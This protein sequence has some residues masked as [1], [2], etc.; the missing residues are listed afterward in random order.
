VRRL[1]TAIAAFVA[2]ISASLPAGAQSIAPGEIVAT[3][4]DAATHAPI[5][6]ATVFLIGTVA[7]ETAITDAHGQWT[8]DDVE[9]GSYGIQIQAGGYDQS[10]VI[11]VEV[12]ENKH[13]AVDIA[14]VP[15]LRTIAS[16]TV[17]ASS[18][19]STTEIG[20]DS[21]ERKV[22]TSL[23]DALSKLVGITVSD[24]AYGPNSGFGISLGNH[25]ESQTGYSINGFG[26]GGLSGAVGNTPDLFTAA[27]VSFAP[28]PG[29]LGGTLNFR[30]VLPTK[31][32]QYGLTNTIGNYGAVTTSAT[33]SGSKGR[34]SVAAQHVVTRGDDQ[35]SG[36][37]YM[38]QSGQS[39]LHEA[40]NSAVG[41]VV[42]ASYVVN[43]RVSLTSSA[44]LESARYSS[45][46]STFTTLVPCGYGPGSQ[47][48]S[49]YG[50]G[51]V[52]ANALVGKVTLS[53]AVGGFRSGFHYDDPGRSL[54]GTVDPYSNVGD[55]SGLNGGFSASITSK[56]H[57]VALNAFGGSSSGVTTLTYDGV[58]LT[59]VEPRQGS[60]R[61]SIY[62]QQKSSERLR[63][64]G[65]FSVT[66]ATGSGT[67]FS[68]YGSANWMARPN[69]T[70]EGSV[71]YGGSQPQYGYAVP[72][73]DPLAASYDCGNHSI[74]LS[75]PQDPTGPQ[76]Q[77]YYGL[78]W[79]HKF[80]GGSV[81]VS[82]SR[83]NELGQGITV[84]VPIAA[85]PD[86][87]FPGGLPAYLSSLQNVWSMP[88]VCGSTPFANNRIYVSQ[89][90]GG[91]GQVYSVMNISARIPM[92]DLIVLPS[93]GVNSAYLS[94][95]DPRLAVAGSYYGIGVQLPHRPLR[96]ADLILDQ[97]IPRA[98]LELFADAHYV[99]INN[100][101]NLPAYTM[102][103]AGFAF[104]AK[105]GTITM[106]ESNIFGT[107][108]G[109]FTTY[110][111]IDPMPVVGGGTFAFASTPLSP[112]QWLFVWKI[113][114]AQHVSPPK[115]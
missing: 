3:V 9:P 35:R 45:I 73:S 33:A 83:Q 96:S 32:W 18:S 76:S 92:G 111:G 64:T 88:N 1:C 102:Y 54:A 31:L 21:A 108:A 4:T 70:I 77:V 7:P 55:Q 90:I 49:S 112:R 28:T 67:S 106:L 94:S 89:L 109:L 62:D 93:Y 2:V 85:E 97:L 81:N 71:L 16:V 100:G 114:W 11:A 22:S 39:Y 78:S 42:V 52:T 46:C 99:G 56:R 13:V 101:N 63:L 65:S 68:T 113:P 58:P 27:S 43:P 26:A 103:S 34:F 87:I 105:L 57:T 74:Y 69:D 15:T 86:S 80:H 50:Y 30:T 40:A 104:K 17:K 37:T 12:G 48:G 66:S 82:L 95:L 91:L 19:I 98:G 8:F 36:L 23:K 61:W 60:W 107:Q 44:L 41:D 38:D 6:N 20:A 10:G 47:S 75:G 84:G 14:L 59:A 5:A 110:R 115:P 53:A 29:S 79:L 51:N 25:D 24:S 72:I